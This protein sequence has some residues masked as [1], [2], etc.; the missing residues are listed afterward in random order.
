[1]VLGDLVFGDNFTRGSMLSS[2][3]SD[4][5]DLPRDDEQLAEYVSALGADSEVVLDKVHQGHLG[6]SVYTYTVPK[7]AEAHARHSRLVTACM[8][9]ERSRGRSAE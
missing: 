4:G 1:M 5:W 6:Y 9:F 3:Y 2:R 7:L 8:D